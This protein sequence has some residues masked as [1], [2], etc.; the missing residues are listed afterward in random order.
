MIQSAIPKVLPAFLHFFLLDVKHFKWKKCSIQLGQWIWAIGSLIT[1]PCGSIIL[2]VY[3]ESC[4]SFESS[5]FSS[6]NGLRWSVHS[7][8]ELFCQS[9]VELKFWIRENVLMNVEVGLLVQQDVRVQVFVYFQSYIW[10]RKVCIL[11]WFTVCNTISI[12]V[13]INV[14]FMNLHSFPAYKW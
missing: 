5:C 3:L 13:S 7:E 8:V 1:P 9:V 14:I 10:T 11:K 6:V 4:I 2:K 12:K